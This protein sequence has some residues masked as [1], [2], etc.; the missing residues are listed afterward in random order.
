[1]WCGWQ[2]GDSIVR[3]WGKRINESRWSKMRTKMR[4]F[5]FKDSV[6]DSFKMSQERMSQYAD[7]INEISPKVIRGY[8]H[9]LY[10]LAMYIRE[11]ARNLTI[12]AC[13]STAE[14]LF[15][16]YREEIKSSLSARCFDQYGCG[17]IRNIAAEC[18]VH[19]GL[20][21]NDE[22]VIVEIVHKKEMAS[23]VGEL[24]VTDLDNYG[25]PFIRYKN[26]DI[27]KNI[28]GECSCG[29]ELSR[30]GEI[31]GRISSSFITKTGTI[32]HG[33]F[34]T[35]LLNELQISQE[36]GIREFQ[37]IQNDYDKYHLNLVSKRELSKS[38]IYHLTCSL[39][40]YL[41]P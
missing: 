1:S 13:S 5:L 38:E 16:H 41:G 2:P 35:H 21:V 23:D 17:E 3:L 39:K 7:R 27:A 31:V 18:E 8:S 4:Q 6:F 33:E 29:R 26:G 25:M 20:H 24:I 37:M 14:M 28:E 22:H 9:S 11:S 12:P 32:V 34:I 36:A 10:L 15:P 30:I 40:Q 19:D